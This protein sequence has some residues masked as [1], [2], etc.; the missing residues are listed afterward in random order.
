[1]RVV[2]LGRENLYDLVLRAVGDGYNIVLMIVCKESD[3]YQRTTTDFKML[4]KKLGIPFIQT[5]NINKSEI[6]KR[7]KEV[8]PDIGMSYHW[9]TL[10]EQ[11]VL[12]CFP[13]GVIN[14]HPGDLPRYKGNAC[15]HWAIMNGED[16]I[17]MTLH[18]MTTELDSGPVILKKEITLSE[19]TYILEIYSHIHDNCPNM[20]MEALDKLREGFTGFP[21]DKDPARSLRCYPRSLRDSEINWNE[22][23]VMLARLVRAVSE[24]LVGAYTFIEDKKLIVWR[25]HYEIPPFPFI[26]SPG[27][28]ADRR[29]NTG[30]V[31]VVTGEGLLVLEEVEIDGIGRIKPTKA[32]KT[33][34]LKLGMDVTDEIMRLKHKLENLKKVLEIVQ[35]SGG[36][37]EKPSYKE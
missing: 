10:I 7:I 8:K 17:V 9:K 21:Q 12:D 11:G 34:R 24:P 26:G 29:V 19:N 33:I 27:Q 22:P 1:M 35:K 5:E 4:A 14:F 16:K 3:F 31:A 30:E 23:A 25:A 13:Q 2:A 6:I 37:L 32:I 28:I 18:L 36:N 15:T 20:Y